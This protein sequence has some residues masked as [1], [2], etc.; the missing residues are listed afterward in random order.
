[1]SIVHSTVYRGGARADST[2]YGLLKSDLKLPAMHAAGES[3]GMSRWGR[4][5]ARD[6]QGREIATGWDVIDDILFRA[7]DTDQEQV[8]ALNVSIDSELDGSE[9]ETPPRRSAA[10]SVSP[11]GDRFRPHREVCEE[12][13]SRYRFGWYSSSHY[14]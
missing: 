11:C 8:D 1:M 9:S 12:A 7:L 6:D 5:K 10:A 4:R 14:P 2:F 3:F 13:R